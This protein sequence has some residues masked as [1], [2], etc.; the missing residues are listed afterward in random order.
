MK[1]VFLILT[2]STSFRAVA[3]DSAAKKRALDST[4]KVI[5]A[6]IIRPAEQA[7]GSLEPNW[8]SIESQVRAS[9]SDIQTDRAI[10]K[11]RIYYYF[12]RD[13]AKFSSAI[14]LYTDAYEDKRDAGLMNKNAG[15][16]LRYSQ[17]PKEWR[18]ALG[19]VQRA[20]EAEPGNA[21]CQAMRDALQAKLGSQ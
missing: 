6:T 9:Y 8:A 2:I 5:I 11:A 18:A 1:T 3:Q 12:N 17:N 7:A 20:L 16:I 15:F 13:W 19:W 4:D 14:V 21:A 10:T